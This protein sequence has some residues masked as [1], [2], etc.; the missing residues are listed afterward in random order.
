MYFNSDYLHFSCYR[1]K[2]SGLLKVCLFVL[3]LRLFQS[4]KHCVLTA[5]SSYKFYSCGVC[6]REFNH[7]F[8][9]CIVKDS[10]KQ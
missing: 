7:F 8:T 6:W 2:L 5:A 3:K 9:C 4:T 10:R 1:R